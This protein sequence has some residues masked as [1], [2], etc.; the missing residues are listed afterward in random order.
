MLVVMLLNEELKILLVHRTY[1]FV[2]CARETGRCSGGK[3]VTHITFHKS[4][5]QTQCCVLL[6]SSMERILIYM[7]DFHRDNRKS[8][9]CIPVTV[10]ESTE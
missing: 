8:L 10:V 4:Q 7:R 1:V 5:E 3:C 6:T 9:R 2:E